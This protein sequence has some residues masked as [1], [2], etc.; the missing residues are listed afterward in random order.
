MIA[1]TSARSPE[2]AELSGF[3]T[4]LLTRANSLNS[5]MESVLPVLGEVF[6]TE[7]VSLVDYYENT[8][9]FDLVYFKGYPADARH[10]LQRRLAEMQVRRA[11]EETR[12][13]HS[14]KNLNFLILPCYFRDILE[15]LV[16]FES[17]FPIELTSAREECALV[18]SRFLGL[19][20]SSTR[21]DVNRTQAVDSQ[22]LERARQ[23]QLNFLPRRP[24]R[25]RRCE[26]YGVN[27]SSNLVGGDYFDYFDNEENLVQSILA[28]ACGHG[29]AAALIMSNFRGILQSEVLRRQGLEGLFSSLND[30]IHF[31]DDLIQYLT[32]VFLQVEE[33]TGRLDYLNAGH[34]EPVVISADGEVRTLP[35]GGPPLGMFKSSRYPVGQAQLHSGD[36]VALYTDGLVDIQNPRDD[37]FGT[38]RV[39]DSLKRHHERP[40]PEITEGVLQEAREFAEGRS[41]EDDVTVSLLRLR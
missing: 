1:D 38:D 21:L 18:V 30:M 28:D 22:D 40:L 7:R 25:T 31:D 36:L 5:Y 14:E 10:T 26:V 16:A 27:N 17:D 2:A 3:L 8:D 11:L 13:Y 4:Y 12:P 6:G 9:H 33:P 19:F 41:F 15:A 39:I 29:M 34:Y 32:G 35:G 20:M 24:P 23:I 37:Y